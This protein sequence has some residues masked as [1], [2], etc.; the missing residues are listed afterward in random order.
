MKKLNQETLRDLCV[1]SSW[2]G[3]GGGFP[4]PLQLRR[5]GELKG[6]I[7]LLSID[8]VPASQNVAC[9]YGVGSA[10][11]TGVDLIPAFREAFRVLTNQCGTSIGGIFPAEIAIESAVTALA[12]ALGIPLI[13]G[14]VVGGRAVPELRQDNCALMGRSIAPIVAC[15]VKGEVLLLKEI[16]SS[17]EAEE[18]LRTFAATS[19]GG[20]IAAIDHCMTAREA[21]HILS[22]GTLSRSIEVGEL[23][24]KGCD[25][26]E[27]CARF[28]CLA[29]VMLRIEAVALQSRGGFLSGTVDGMADD[30]S[31]YR[32]H[33][34]NE[35]MKFGRASAPPMCS[36]P[37]LICV[38]DP[39]RGE[40][41]HSTE[42]RAGMRV[43]VVVFEASERWRSP[44]ARALFE[45]LA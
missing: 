5:M 4:L 3:T 20:S 17:V 29:S 21:A 27:I 8:E 23:V 32:L 18:K 45:S 37:D 44:E 36:A 31:P 15:N 34:K 43:H 28:S 39:A 6:E 25:V 9:A 38:L 16:E 1:G 11:S 26:E 35:Y 7:V 10:A 30:T 24:R 12:S 42:L 41:L 13:D 2:F 40:G 33:V 14:D 19:P 22:I